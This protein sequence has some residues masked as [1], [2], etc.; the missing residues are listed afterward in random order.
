MD[1]GTGHCGSCPPQ[2]MHTDQW[3][4]NGAM[5]PE[6]A[7]DP[8]LL[9]GLSTCHT[10]RAQPEGPRPPDSSGPGNGG[11]C[12]PPGPPGCCPGTREGGSAS[13]RQAQ[14]LGSVA[15]A[16]PLTGSCRQEQGSQRGLAGVGFEAT[17]LALV[18]VVWV[19]AVRHARALTDHL[20]SAGPPPNAQS[21]TQQE[22]TLGL[23]S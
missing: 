11:D 2:Q 17:G 15:R 5:R 20:L 8:A 16:N 4:P 3:L 13:Q 19:W 10:Q 22:R 6:P 1:A 12:E 14:S 18:L 9:R 21:L 23:I 7:P